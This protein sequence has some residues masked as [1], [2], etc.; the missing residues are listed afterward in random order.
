MRLDEL[1]HLQWTSVALTHG[2]IAIR[3]DKVVENRREIPL[4][5]V[6]VA[7]LRSMTTES[8]DTL[9]VK[10][11][12]ALLGGWRIGPR[13]LASLQF[14]N[15]DLAR[16]VLVQKSIIRWNPKTSNRTIP[17]A[18]GLKPILESQPRVSNLVCRCKL[19]SLHK[20]FAVAAHGL[21]ADICLVPA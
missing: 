18:P 21:L 19:E 11:R 15:F 4:A 5:P 12:Q 1:R 6:T 3:Q 14:K 9:E 2:E 17:I 7:A 16:C 13:G 20:F 10:Q 8:F